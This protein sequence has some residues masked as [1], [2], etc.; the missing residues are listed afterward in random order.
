MPIREAIA[1][2][3]GYLGGGVLGLVAGALVAQRSDVDDLSELGIVLAWMVFLAFVGAT[4]GGWIA[5]RVVG[6]SSSGITGILA[7]AGGFAWSVALLALLA[8]LPDGGDA[9][10]GW[11]GLAFLAFGV[12]LLARWLVARIERP[13]R[14]EA[15]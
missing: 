13:T 5:L 12:P 9:V 8:R 7:G 1:I 10:F 14:E 3:V 4:A 6:A 11:A 2:I 15:S